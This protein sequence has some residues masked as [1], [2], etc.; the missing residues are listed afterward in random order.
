MSKNN[1]KTKFLS[2]LLVVA[3]VV[4]MMPMTAFAVIGAD[5][6]IDSE[7]PVTEVLDKEEHSSIPGQP[8]VNML[9][10]TTIVLNSVDGCEYSLGGDVWQESYVF[11]DL[12]PSTTYIVYQRYAETDATYASQVS[13]L[14]EV[15]T[16]G[17][18][19]D[20]IAPKLISVEGNVIT[21]E[22][23]AGYEYKY[24]GGE[25]QD[26]NVF[27]LDS[28]TSYEFVQR[29]KETDDIEASEISSSIFVSTER[30]TE[31][32]SGAV[33]LYTKAD[34]KEIKN[35]TNSNA[36]YVLMKDIVF[37]DADFQEY[38]E[39]Y[40]EG[41]GWQ[42]INVFRG[43]IDGNGYKIKNLKCSSAEKVNLI[44]INYGEVV[45]LALENVELSASNVDN[46]KSTYVGGIAGTNMGLINGCSISGSIKIE[47]IDGTY[48][49]GAYIG[50]ICTSN[51]GTVNACSSATTIVA[52]A[53]DSAY[54]GGI[55]GRNETN[56]IVENSYNTG[57]VI[58]YI[59]D[60]YNA[61]TYTGG[62]VG[63][64]YGQVNACY[65][66]GVLDSQ[67]KTSL[68][69]AYTGAIVGDNY[70]SI[71]QCYYSELQRTSSG[72][73]EGTNSAKK[74]ELKDL[75]KPSSYE[76]F[77]FENTWAI[78]E[79]GNGTP[80]LKNKV[81]F[82]IQEN[83][84][85]FAG[86]TGTIL[87]P[88]M[89][90]SKREL[91]NVNNHLGAAYILMNNISFEQKDFMEAGDFYNDG[92]GW[93]S[94]GSDCFKDF[95]GTFDG[96]N[97]SISGLTVRNQAYMGLFGYARG[98][99]KNISVNDI[100]IENDMEKTVYAGGVVGAYYGEALLNCF[101]SVEMDLTNTY[102]ITAGGVAGIAKEGFCRCGSSGN[103]KLDSSICSGLNDEYA[104]GLAA[105]CGG[106]IE[107]S[108]SLCDV[109]LK[110]YMSNNIYIG[111]LVGYSSGSL[112]KN[113]YTVGEIY[114]NS[115][116]YAEKEHST[117]LCGKNDG[118][119]VSNSY[120][121]CD[122][123]SV[124]INGKDI[125]KS[126]SQFMS[127]EVA[128]L[129]NNESSAS[130]VLWRQNLGGDAYPVQ[131]DTHNIVYKCD[132]YNCQGQSY[133]SNYSNNDSPIYEK[134][135]IVEYAAQD[136]TCSSVG[137]NSYE[138]CRKC[139]YSTYV[140]VDK[141]KHKWGNDYTLDKTP[142]CTQ[143]GS[144][145]IHC[146]ECDAKKE[147]IP[148]AALGHSY[149]LCVTKATMSSDGTI[150]D[151]CAICGNV[152]SEENIYR[153]SSVKL[154]AVNYT[155]TGSSKKPSVTVKDSKGTTLKN[156]TDYS[157][158]YASGRTKIG[159]YKVTVTFKGNYSGSKALYFE[160][161]PKN[162]STVRTALYGYDDVKVSWS[163]VS[164]ASGYKVYYKKATASSW[165]LLKTTTATSYKKANLSD[166]VK[167]NFKVFA[168][169]KVNGNACEN[170]GKTSSIFTLKKVAG[171]KVAKSGSKVKVSWTNIS[172]ETGYQISQA[173]SKSKTKIVATYKTTSGK[174]KT[175]SAKKGKIYYYKVRAYKV[176]DGKKIYGPWSSAV[177][178]KR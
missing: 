84:H 127:G 8:T 116:F 30:I 152:K 81:S 136:P 4:T 36:H 9:T 100:S 26:D 1:F 56:G 151:I 10:S 75:A 78:S 41:V 40:N 144:K 115:N 50:G 16:K 82:K 142:T 92:K 53:Y 141:L 74:I 15:T 18:P 89:I 146:S 39:F 29:Q 138:A 51:Y 121:L 103:L 2:L 129:L 114:S 76:G 19:S 66:I 87:S 85:E 61:Y 57:E 125:A 166:G 104:G 157:V 163:K 155:Y 133:D 113:S 28:F 34:L 101:S 45:N 32:P 164:G 99:I 154:S 60:Q 47:N 70:G 122:D 153:I 17:K 86:G 58:T 79:D 174:Y 11:T 38:G 12:E 105:R 148:V 48:A 107:D 126:K 49:S 171:V 175:V 161:G 98:N 63:K 109:Y 135:D 102:N 7:V 25:W 35:N 167:Y 147:D 131:D 140:E 156:G 143:S 91:A 139:D 77:D 21:L 130:S 159:K 80:Y 134:H 6:N 97:N 13:P 43:K 54:A 120:V 27:V 169:K 90:T 20:V 168:Y 62:I 72:E 64:N 112:I 123:K 106:N 172:G 177:K 83:T 150:K 162:P 124:L 46:T 108:Y 55:V 165:T 37:I 5:E 22:E 132:V 3:L 173:T 128:Y 42:S 31:L 59:D 23:V 94:L 170:A 71:N 88:Y 69:G 158:S 96:Q 117:K 178:Y 137:W 14:L 24:I 67:R 145:S 73:E 52:E 119:D 65:N 44:H 149:K 118:L 93:I 68:L 160:I 95:E 176:V 111:G 33:G 110:H